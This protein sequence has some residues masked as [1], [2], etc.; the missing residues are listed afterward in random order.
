[1]H[2][3]VEQGVP[4]EINCGGV[5][6]GRKAELYP[7][8]ELLHALHDFGGEILINSDWR[9]PYRPG[10]RVARGT[11]PPAVRPTA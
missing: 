2:T 6:R 8:H 11:P 7:R 10:S 1:M 5:N 4:F 9:R 3:D